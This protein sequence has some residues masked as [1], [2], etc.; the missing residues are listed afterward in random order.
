MGNSWYIICILL[1]FIKGFPVPRMLKV[2]AVAGRSVILNCSLRG[3]NPEE[4]SVQWRE[5]NIT[6]MFDIIKGIETVGQEY[7]DKVQS[8]PEE[9]QKGNYSIKIEHLQ[10]T[11]AG[12]Y[13]CLI[14]ST[15]LQH[16]EI[17]VLTI[18]ERPGGTE[19]TETN[20]TSSADGSSAV[21]DVM[22]FFWFLFLFCMH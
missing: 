13:L 3:I 15:S 8:F 20:L 4:I 5:D 19:P 2:E 6:F 21:I 17:I 1:P 7:K 22:W 16:S 18:K 10:I 11:D 9:Y 14:T 12:K